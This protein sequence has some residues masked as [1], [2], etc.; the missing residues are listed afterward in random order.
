MTYYSLPNGVKRMPKELAKHLALVCL[1]FQSDL[2]AAN[3]RYKFWLAGK[4]VEYNR[5]RPLGSGIIIL[6]ELPCYSHI[7]N[8]ISK[9]AFNVHKLV[10]KLHA[11]AYTLH[12]LANSEI[13]MKSIESIAAVLLS[14]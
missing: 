12:G 14:K 8:A 10:P 13:F 5:T 3:V 6:V 1:L 2:D 9:R 7:L 11:L 4:V